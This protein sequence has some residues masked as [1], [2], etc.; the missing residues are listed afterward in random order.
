MKKTCTKCHK[1]KD[2]SEFGKSSIWGKKRS[3]CRQ[4]DRESKKA[5]TERKKQIQMSLDPSVPEKM[6][7]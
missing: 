4:C 6:I 5:Y 7:K 2:I 3:A 1:E